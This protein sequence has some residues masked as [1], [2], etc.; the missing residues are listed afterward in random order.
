MI[1]DKIEVPA[2]L[3]NDIVKLK[4]RVRDRLDRGFEMGKMGSLDG[5]LGLL[6]SELDRLDEI[7]EKYWSRNT[8]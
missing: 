6:L 2:N 3:L 4:G 1:T 7:M 5:D 8:K